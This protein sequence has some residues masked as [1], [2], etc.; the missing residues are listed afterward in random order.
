MKGFP[1]WAVSGNR[2]AGRN[3]PNEIGFQT[4]VSL[5]HSVMRSKHQGNGSKGKLDFGSGDRG[6]RPPSADP[7]KPLVRFSSFPFPNISVQ[8]NG[9]QGNDVVVTMRNMPDKIQHLSRAFDT[10]TRQGVDDKKSDGGNP[11]LDPPFSHTH[12]RKFTSFCGPS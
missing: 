5:A 11:T 4:P 8:L 12:S 10:R 7:I 1:K 2:G 3:C 6:R 9:G